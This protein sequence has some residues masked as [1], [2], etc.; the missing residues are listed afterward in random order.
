[1]DHRRVSDELALLPHQGM[2]TA[3][4][5]LPVGVGQIVEHLRQQSPRRVAVA[6]TEIGGMGGA[7]LNHAADCAPYP[8]F[9][10]MSAR[11]VSME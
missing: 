4:D 1:M 6:S 9:F 7:Q 5:V 10:S 3:Q 11:Y 2:H 8:R